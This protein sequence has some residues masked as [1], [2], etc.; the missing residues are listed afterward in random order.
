MTTVVI[1]GA[2]EYRHEIAPAFRRAWLDI[3]A[4]GC[5]GAGQGG[6]DRGSVG[7]G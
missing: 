6:A 5:T 3:E 4:G 7:V 1:T 2:G